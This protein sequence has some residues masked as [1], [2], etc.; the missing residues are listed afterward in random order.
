MVK[1]RRFRYVLMVLLAFSFLVHKKGFAEKMTDE[2]LYR[3]LNGLHFN[4]VALCSEPCNRF[5]AWHQKLG[6]QYLEK[7]APK[8]TPEQPDREIPAKPVNF[9]CTYVK[10]ISLSAT[11]E[12]KGHAPESDETKNFDGFGETFLNALIDG[13]KK[14]GG[15]NTRHND[16]FS[17]VFTCE[18]AACVDVNTGKVLSE[19]KW[20][21]IIPAECS[22]SNNPTID[23]RTRR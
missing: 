8:A 10:A 4:C 16:F 7:C 18:A 14:C 19:E 11:S 1:Q 13:C 3:F 12:G 9:K 2:Q 6:G 23:R 17:L 15:N 21:N 20:A 22:A 5:Y